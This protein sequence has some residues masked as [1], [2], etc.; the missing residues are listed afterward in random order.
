[1]AIV[2]LMAP[3]VEAQSTTNPPGSVQGV[4]GTGAPPNPGRTTQQLSA[5]FDLGGG[6]DRNL[7]EPRTLALAISGEGNN[8]S[9]F[10]LVPRCTM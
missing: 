10:P 3:A 7:L 6:Y 1:M 4:F 5:W 8:N 2:F 9:Q